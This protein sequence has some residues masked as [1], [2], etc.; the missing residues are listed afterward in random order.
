MISPQLRRWLAVGSGIGIEIQ[1]DDLVIIAVR[2]RF[3]RVQVLDECRIRGFASRPAAD[4]GAEYQQFLSSAGLGHLAAHVL[5]PRE[6][7]IVRLLSLPAIGSKELAAAIGFQIDSLHPYADE[8]VLHAWAQ[9]ER[10]GEVVVAVARREVVGRYETLFAEAGIQLASFSVAAAAFYSSVRL[11]EDPRTSD[12]V[13]FE[14]SEGGTQIYGESSAKALFSAFIPGPVG[15]ALSIAAAELRLS[16]EQQPLSLTEILPVPENRSG[17]AQFAEGEWEK[18]RDQTVEAGSSAGTAMVAVAPV[19][20]TRANEAAASSRAYAV[21]LSAACPLLSLQVNLLPKQARKSNSRILYL[22]TVVF[23][24]VLVLCAIAL[25]AENSWEQKRYLKRLHAE[26]SRLE[27]IAERAQ[28]MQRSSDDTKNKIREIDSF[29]SRSR[30]DLD[31]INELTRILPPPTWVSSLD[32]NRTGVLLAGD[33]PD[34]AGLLKT[35]DAS[36]LFQG[37][38]FQQSIVRNSANTDVFRVKTQRE[39]VVP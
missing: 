10:K 17:I 15:R 20:T 14:A 23:A 21:A 6:S 16:R 35:I 18:I 38:A 12:F 39:Q 25:A 8:D 2:V 11:F 1:G 19:A 29:R 33:T 9:L 5:L 4:W 28:R 31:A 13:A 32:L 22:P 7:V 26:I 3:G 27:P 24:L 30:A 36:P 34:A 37:S